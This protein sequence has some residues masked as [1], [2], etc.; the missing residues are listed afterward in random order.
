MNRISRASTLLLIIALAACSGGGRA[1]TPPSTLPQTTGRAATTITIAVPPKHADSSTA[2]VRKAA[3]ISPSAQSIA[4][5]AGGVSTVANLTPSSPGCAAATPAFTEYAFTAGNPVAIAAGPDGNLWVGANENF[6]ASI[7]RVTPAGVMTSYPVGGAD[8]ILSL[9]VG[10]DGQLWFTT[11]TTTIEK[12]GSISTSGVVQQY[13][14]PPVGATQRSTQGLTVGADGNLWFVDNANGSVDPV[15]VSGSFGTRNAVGFNEDQ[16]T[17]GPDGNLWI[18]GAA[19]NVRKVS[20]GGTVV[21]YTLPR[22]GSNGDFITNG[23]DGALWF[24]EGSYIGRITTA[25]A[26]SE[27]ALTNGA[28]GPITLGPDGNMWFPEYSANAIASITPTGG[29]AEYTIP[30][31]QSQPYAIATGPDGNIWFSEWNPA[32]S[33]AKLGKLTPPGTTCSITVNVPVGPAVQV[34][35][36]LYDGPNGTGNALATTLAPY[37]I[38]TAGPNTIPLVL[39]GVVDH[40]DVHL[41]NTTITA[42][43]ARTDGVMVDARDAQ[44]NLIISPGSYVDAHNDPLTLTLTDS[45]TS[46]ATTLTPPSITAPSASVQLNYTGGAPSSSTI[47]IGVSIT[48]GTITGAITPATLTVQ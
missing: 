23:P 26:V 16:L 15:S 34:G 24:T 18:V 37:A 27:F 43:T 39:N 30:T 20:L 45:D 19:N 13:S 29:V 41:V 25:G 42:G 14:P 2:S 11:G 32:Q 46:G 22:P 3:Y 28:N 36:T 31:A 33:I 9:I 35:A 17:S 44:N 8:D 6:T 48:G 7:V 12:V 10:P 38:T 4:I 21:T 1:V 5:T 40:V 47:S